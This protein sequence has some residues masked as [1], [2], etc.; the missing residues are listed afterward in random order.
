MG[1]ILQT[2]RFLVCRFATQLG[3]DDIL[4]GKLNSLRTLNFRANI[5]SEYILSPWHTTCSMKFI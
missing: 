5:Y 1:E 4:V 3:Q 2:T